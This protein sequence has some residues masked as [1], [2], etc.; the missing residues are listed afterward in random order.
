MN[1]LMGVIGI[2]VLIGIAL[3][4]SENR[5]AIRLRTVSI[6]FAIQALIGVVVLYTDWGG[7]LLQWISNGVQAVLGSA[8]AGI[9]FLF[10]G[11]VSPQMFEVF[12]N[13]GF[14][15]AF[16][17]LP[18]IVFFSSLIAVL[19]YLGVMRWVINVIGRG[20]Q[21]ALGTSRAESLNSAANIFVGQSEAPLVVKP[22][23]PKMTRS[24]LFA[25]M[26]GGLA[27]VAGSTL[28]GYAA[29]GIDLNYLLAASFMAAPGG[30]LMAKLII[31]ETGRP[32]QRLEE[33]E[34]DD[35][36]QQGP[37]N[38]ID[39]AAAGA[40]D[41]L[42]LAVNVGAM[43]IAFVALIALFN[44]MV[45]SI[46][47]WFGIE[48]LSLQLIL[49]YCFAPLAFLIGI[50]WD[51]AITAGSLIGQKTILNE[52]VAYIDFVAVRDSLTP[53][54][55]AIVIFALCG[56]ANLSSVAILLGGLGVIAPNRRGDV[57]S[58]GL[59]A[60][61]AGTL[62]NLMSACLAGLLLAL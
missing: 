47:G 50:P 22:F 24:E 21:L 39:A 57:A 16:R 31:P 35:A 44:G 40:S 45:G 13:G 20:L 43:L 41:G 2:A 51:E 42:R 28:G 30:L 15:F 25:V 34:P 5:R 32:H 19:Y 48:E 17:V 58:L 61:L 55:Q 49:G 29:L 52:F 4:F 38:V 46:G 56:F 7:Q 10:G 1:I 6:A 60:V 36:Q 8:D 33:V 54:S 23:V 27:S 3:L 14:V 53:H 59:K 26:A 9:S 37:R 18:I 11:L 62:S 12:G